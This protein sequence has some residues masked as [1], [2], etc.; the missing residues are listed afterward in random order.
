VHYS[1]YPESALVPID[2]VAF[3]HILKEPKHESFHKKYAL[4]KF[5]K[6]SVKEIA[7]G[8]GR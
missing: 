3:K 7:E 4:K 5:S 8:E 1:S 6:A 2:G